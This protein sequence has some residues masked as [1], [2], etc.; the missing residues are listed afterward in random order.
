MKV[1]EPVGV[2]PPVDGGDGITCAVNVTVVPRL[3]GFGAAV[4]VVVVL[5]CWTVTVIP[6]E[7][8]GEKLELPE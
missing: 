5:A 4:S 2:G 7:V 3:A 6:V 1:I 8:L